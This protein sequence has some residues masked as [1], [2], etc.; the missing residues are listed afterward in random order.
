MARLVEEQVELETFLK[1]SQQGGSDKRRK[2]RNGVEENY[3][4]ERAGMDDSYMKC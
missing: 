1:T 3:E 4:D 2:G